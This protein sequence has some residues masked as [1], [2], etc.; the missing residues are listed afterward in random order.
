MAANHSQVHVKMNRPPRFVFPDPSAPLLE[1]NPAYAREMTRLALNTVNGPVLV[2]F[3]FLRH[4]RLLGKLPVERNVVWVKPDLGQYAAIVVAELPFFIGRNLVEPSD[5]LLAE[6]VEAM[7]E[8]SGLSLWIADPRF[9]AAD[10]FTRDCS[11]LVPSRSV[12][13]SPIFADSIPFA[14]REGVRSHEYHSESAMLLQGGQMVF[15]KDFIS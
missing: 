11:G 7:V 14:F 15:A 12:A 3:N 6:L 4:V 2:M 9:P 5:W 13:A 1:H 10:P 8:D